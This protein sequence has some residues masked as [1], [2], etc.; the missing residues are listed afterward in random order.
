MLAL[1]VVRGITTV[2]CFAVTVIAHPGA[3]E[4]QYARGALGKDHAFDP[5]G[6]VEYRVHTGCAVRSQGLVILRVVHQ[7]RRIAGVL[8]IKG[9]GGGAVGGA[10]DNGQ[11]AVPGQSRATK[12]GLPFGG[13]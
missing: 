1:A 13:N 6:A 2:R 5:G 8:R 11:T 7:G 10:A 4:E 9:E 3:P 12:G